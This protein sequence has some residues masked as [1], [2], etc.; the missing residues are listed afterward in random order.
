[1]WR[2][3]LHKS[4]KHLTFACPTAAKHLSTC[5]KVQ[6]CPS[7]FLINDGLEPKC[8]I[9]GLTLCLIARLEELLHP[10]LS[11]EFNITSCFPCF[12]NAAS[13]CWTGWG[14]G[15]WELW[16]IDAQ[17]DLPWSDVLSSSG[18]NQNDLPR[19]KVYSLLLHHLDEWI[20]RK[21]FSGNE[22][23]KKLSKYFNILPK[24]H[25]CAGTVCEAALPTASHSICALK[26][27]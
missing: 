25:L 17:S 23:E 26:L 3:R 13:I 10:V 5:L 15:L 11:R 18:G 19:M 27:W 1:M 22:K 9:S 24:Y 12:M 14:H 16:S 8:L 2:H 7:A 20:L 4:F 21:Q 6:T